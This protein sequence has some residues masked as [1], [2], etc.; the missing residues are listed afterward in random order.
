MQTQPPKYVSPPGTWKTKLGLRASSIVFVIIL[1]GLG[2]SLAANPRLS[3]TAWMMVALA[4]AVIVT[5]IWD[6][7]EAICILKR[8]GNRGIHPGAIVGVDLLAWLGWAILDL[9]LASYGLLRARYL[10]DDYSGYDSYRYR[11]DPSKVTAED[12]ALEKD[13]QARG[14]AMV[15]FAIMTTLIHFALFVIG[16]YE[17]NIR[18]RMPRTVYVMQPIYGPAPVQIPGAYQ[19][20]GSLPAQSMPGQPMQGQPLPNQMFMQPPPGPFPV[21]PAPTLAANPKAGAER[22]A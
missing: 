7:A 6:I 9:F 17:T 10:I 19:Q 3:S 12:A 16:C 18:N 2:G 21:Q 8:S 5:F 22:F 15:A 1:A 13:V 11:Y 4:P 14:R 20:L